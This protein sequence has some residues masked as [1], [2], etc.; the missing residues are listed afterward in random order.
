MRAARVGPDAWH[1]STITDAKRVTTT[2]QP[3]GPPA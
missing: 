3:E 2:N 1:M